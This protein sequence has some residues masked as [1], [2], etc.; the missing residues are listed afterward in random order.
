MLNQDFVLLGTREGKMELTPRHLLYSAL[1]R[2][3]VVKISTPEVSSVL[4]LQGRAAFLRLCREVPHRELVK[5]HSKIYY[6]AA[7]V[8]NSTPDG[9]TYKEGAL[10]PNG[11]T[12]ELEWHDAKVYIHVTEAWAHL[13]AVQTLAEKY[14]ALRSFL[15]VALKIRAAFE[16]EALQLLH[17]LSYHHSDF[18]NT[19]IDLNGKIPRL[20]IRFVGYEKQP[21]NGEAPVMSAKVHYDKSGITLTGDESGPGLQAGLPDGSTIDLEG[22]AGHSYVF[23]GLFAQ[24]ITSTK[25]NPLSATPHSVVQLLGASVDERFSRCSTIAFVDPTNAHVTYSSYAE[26]HAVPT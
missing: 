5:T 14:P 2:H 25:T 16:S 15:E 7:L 11:D 9:Y 6:G 18:W 17:A 8:K 4:L 26:T 19:F 23:A 13:P 3:G 1:R 24:Q 10:K 12:G 21:A 22:E 20:V